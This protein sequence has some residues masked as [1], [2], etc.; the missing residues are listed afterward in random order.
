MEMVGT[1]EAEMETERTKTMMDR[2]RTV[3]EKTSEPLF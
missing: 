1:M 3:E 2:M